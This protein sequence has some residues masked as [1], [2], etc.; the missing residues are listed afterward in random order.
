MARLVLLGFGEAESLVVRAV[1]YCWNSWKT[2]SVVFH[3]FNGFHSRFW[4]W[5]VQG[6]RGRP[7]TLKV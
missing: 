5:G 6:G 3:S 7:T 1:E 4:G 2:R